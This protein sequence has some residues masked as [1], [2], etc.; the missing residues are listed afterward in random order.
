MAPNASYLLCGT[1][2]TGSTLL[3][4]LLSSTGV[5]GRP[6]SY[7]RE[8]DEAAWAVRFGLA[9]EGRR[10]RDYNAFV[11]AVRAAATTGNG[12]F[13]ARI[14]WGS[15]E[16]IVTGLGTSRG[17]T[18][19][20]TLEGAFGPL[21]FVHLRRQ[22]IVGQ[23]VSW[24]RA[25][26]TGFWQRGDVPSRPLEQD[27]DRM[28]GLVR[29]IRDHDAAWRSWFDRHGVPP[30]DVT[31]EQLVHDR[32]TTVDGIA[33]H[34]EVKVPADWQPS[35]PHQQQA[36]EVNAQWAAALRAALER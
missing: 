1:P 23:A 12:I 3:C 2:R 18:D 33:A 22:D 26:Q 30:H 31:Y 13:A 7:F 4:S 11:H 25:E 16:R 28:R 19:L 24:C 35:S 17:Q 27:L 6:Q 5:L 34:L 21:T 14:M 8:P 20:V 15:V 36:D 32:R 10:V 9:T 29:T